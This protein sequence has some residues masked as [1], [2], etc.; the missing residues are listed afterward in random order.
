M[1]PAAIGVRAEVRLFGVRPTVIG[2]QAEAQGTGVRTRGACSVR[3]ARDHESEPT[4]WPGIWLNGGLQRSQRRV[5]A[6][7]R[8]IQIRLV[9]LSFCFPPFPPFKGVGRVVFITPSCSGQNLLLLFFAP[10]PCPC[11]TDLEQRACGTACPALLGGDPVAPWQ[12]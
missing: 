6:H 9:H 5:G 7:Q 1:R 11:Y 3:P 4:R 2:V 12:C 8:D 10:G